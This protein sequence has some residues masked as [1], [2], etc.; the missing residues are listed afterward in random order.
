MKNLFH[1][2]GSRGKRRAVITVFTDDGSILLQYWR[3]WSVLISNCSAVKYLALRLMNNE[4]PG[5]PG[6]MRRGAAAFAAQRLI[7][8]ELSPDWLAPAAKGLSRCFGRL[9]LAASIR[10]KYGWRRWAGRGF[11][12]FLCS[13]QGGVS[14]GLL[15]G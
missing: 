8:R 15:Q 5:T 14:R 3:Y 11:F 1:H 7:W 10:S 2:R 6:L 4:T 13:S 12:R 9:R